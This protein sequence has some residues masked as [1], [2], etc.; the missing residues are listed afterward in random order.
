VR[1]AE[2]PEKPR[3]TAH[4]EAKNLKNGLFFVKK[5]VFGLF[6]GRFSP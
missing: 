2:K 4:F 6:F 3:K 1:D 5:R